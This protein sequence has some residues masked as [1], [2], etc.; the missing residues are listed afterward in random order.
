MHRDGAGPVPGVQPVPVDIRWHGLHARAGVSPRTPM[1]KMGNTPHVPFIS[2]FRV[3]R[4][5]KS[6][7]SQVQ[8]DS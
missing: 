7:C 1:L 4:P 2:K 8:P 5:A 3:T 6:V